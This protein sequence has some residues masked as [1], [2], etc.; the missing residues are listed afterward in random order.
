[1]AS[2]GD[3]CVASLAGSRCY[4][5]PPPLHTHTQMAHIAGTKRY[6]YIYVYIF[7]RGTRRKPSPHSHKHTLYQNIFKLYSQSFQNRGGLARAWWRRGCD[8]SQG[9]FKAAIAP[10]GFHGLTVKAHKG[11]D[12]ALYGP[13]RQSG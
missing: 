10:D 3:A 13:R 7:K 8:F 5:G 1:M 6:I 9:K 12:M 11:C 2:S 4:V